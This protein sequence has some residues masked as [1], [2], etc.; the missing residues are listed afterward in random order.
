METVRLFL[1]LSKRQIALIG[2][3]VF[4]VILGLTGISGC[5]NEAG[6]PQKQTSSS[7]SST[8]KTVAR[9]TS[10]VILV[11]DVWP[12]Y[13]CTPQDNNEGYMIDV[14]REIF[15]PLGYKVDYKIVPWPRA[16]AGTLEGSYDGAIGC[17]RSEGPELVFPEQELLLT[18]VAFFTLADNPWQFAG[19][20]SL[21]NVRLGV[22]SEYDYVDW[23]DAYIVRE[24][25][26]RDKVQ[27]VTGYRPL[28]QNLR[29]LVKKEIDVLV[30]NGDTVKYEVQQL[31]LTDKIKMA[32]MDPQSIP[33]FI[34]FSP[35]TPSGSRLAAEFDEGMRRLR[36]T[37]RFAEI[38][39]AYGLADWVPA[40]QE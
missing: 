33:C 30:G 36:S 38:L 32:G 2:L 28:E 22:T 26:D 34:G 15:E 25:D 29:K 19:E 13:N 39:A 27:A 40:A 23:L 12:P 11:A 3:L 9:D 4:S 31:G 35:G 6:L 17:A 16:L 5:G 1:L 21:N 10:T 37:G 14:A 8:T 7:D 20:A 24:A 18:S